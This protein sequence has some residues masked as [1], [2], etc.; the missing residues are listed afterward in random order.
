[1]SI[2]DILLQPAKEN[3]TYVFVQGFSKTADKA[4]VKSVFTRYG[5]V[6]GIDYQNSSW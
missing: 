3:G 5:D 1:M 4:L 6:V 2:K